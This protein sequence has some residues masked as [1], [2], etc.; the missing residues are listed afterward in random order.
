MD[1][2]KGKTQGMNKALKIQYKIAELFKKLTIEGTNALDSEVEAYSGR[3]VETSDGK[4]I[5]SAMVKIAT[6]HAQ[7]LRITPDIRGLRQNE[8]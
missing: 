3:M 2:G 1:K 6:K 7:A 8:I 4:K 5:Y